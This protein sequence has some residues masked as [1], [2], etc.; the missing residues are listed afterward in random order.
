MSELYQINLVEWEFMI[1]LYK[2][3][4]FYNETAEF[5]KNSADFNKYLQ[6]IPR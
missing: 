2:K 5:P 4:R 3:I 1:E 6:K